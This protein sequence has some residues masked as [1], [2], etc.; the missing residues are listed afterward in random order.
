MPF[1]VDASAPWLKRARGPGAESGAPLTDKIV[2]FVTCGSCREA[3]KIARR[4]VESK[5]AA[6][7]NI[8]A[9]IESIYRWKGKVQDDR[10]YLLLIKTRTDLFAIVEASIRALHSYSIPEMIAV[11]I[12][13][14][15]QDYM[16][17]FD[18]SLEPSNLGKGGHDPA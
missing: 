16:Q 6:C 8:S 11:P 1:Y 18:D 4:L 14:G 2:I 3:K 7:V 12:L 10:E 9:P 5:L 15:S 17:W 13:E